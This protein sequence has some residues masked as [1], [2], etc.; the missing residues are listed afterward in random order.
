MLKRL[1]NRISKYGNA[2]IK[3][4]R[5]LCYRWYCPRCNNWF[6][7]WHESSHDGITETDCNYCGETLAHSWLL[8]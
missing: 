1:I 8:D 4:G 6:E 2:K 5:E 3:Q 7:A